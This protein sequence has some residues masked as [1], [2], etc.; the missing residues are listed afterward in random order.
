MTALVRYD[1]ARSALSEAVRVD[2]V[3]DILDKSV[4]MQVYARQA[5]DRELE[6]NAAEI[7]E[8]ATRRLGEL[9]IVAKDAKQISRGQPPKNCAE[10]EQFSRVKLD[11]LGIDRKLSSKAQRTAGI[12][13]QAFDMM[14]ARMRSNILDGS[15]S[16]DVLK[17]ETVAEGQA[18]R[19]V[20]EDALSDQSALMAGGRKFPVIYADPA[21]KFRAGIGNR[22]IEN[23]YVT[24]TMDK[25]CAL[26]VADRCLPNARLYVWTTVPQLADTITRILPAWGFEYSSCCCWDKTE[27]DH[28]NEMATGFVFRNQHEL[29]IYATRGKPA[30]PAVV[31]MSMYRERKREHSRKPDYY[32]EMI[33]LMT[34]GTID[35]GAWFGGLPVLEMFARID[36][37]HPLPPRWESWGNQ[38]TDS[39]GNTL[40]ADPETG[41]I[42]ETSEAV[43]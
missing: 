17:T 10:P 22:S 32:R 25:I 3:K 12:A 4:A 43:E 31:P 40:N 42:V 24:M 1:A 39:S 29:L 41:E 36:A 35:D 26:P 18:K 16:A 15:R 37:E 33:H 13:A 34:G 5:Q 30:G 23:H 7:R 2:E 9:I 28:P 14:V 20:L 21:T 19:R 38:A 11:D 8:R 6:A 27:P